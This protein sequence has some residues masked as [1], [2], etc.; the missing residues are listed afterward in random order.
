ME[1]GRHSQHVAL[2]II[3]ELDLPQRFLI[4]VAPEL[5][6]P[7]LL[8]NDDYVASILAD[9]ASKSE[10]G[11]TL[12]D[13]DLPL[14]DRPVYEACSQTKSFK[15]Y[16]VSDWRNV[17]QANVQGLRSEDAGGCCETRKGWRESWEAIWIECAFR[18]VYVII[19]KTHAQPTP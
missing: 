2:R 7:L 3:T 11:A 13:E 6:N 1:E 5:P 4:R 12:S 10:A 16:L 15:V 19:P 14:E 18:L 17:T 9:G 8:D